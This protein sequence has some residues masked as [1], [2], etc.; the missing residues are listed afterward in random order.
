MNKMKTQH[1]N[2]SPMQNLVKCGTSS[3]QKG[4]RGERLWKRLNPLPERERNPTREAFMGQ[5]PN[6]DRG[7]ATNNP[8]E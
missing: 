3:C 6:W 4:G 7:K 1:R 2:S 5:H 8:L